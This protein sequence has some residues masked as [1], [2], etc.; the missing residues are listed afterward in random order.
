MQY[1]EI[2]IDKAGRLVIP[3]EIRQAMRL[4]DQ[5]TLQLRLVNGVLELEPQP[6]PVSLKKRGRLTV[7]KIPRNA[8]RVT[9]EDIE[10][11]RQGILTDRTEQ[12]LA[13]SRRK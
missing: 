5:A 6:T 1:V 2:K 9:P 4:D 10:Q 12:V 3:T 11:V 8:P 13:E 7:A